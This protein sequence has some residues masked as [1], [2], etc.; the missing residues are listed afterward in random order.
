MNANHCNQ[1]TAIFGFR[2]E[3]YEETP[4]SKAGYKFQVTKRGHL[5]HA[6]KSMYETE[7]KASKAAERYICGRMKRASA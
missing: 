4:W 1:E 3:R 7:Q 5:F 6:G 2:V